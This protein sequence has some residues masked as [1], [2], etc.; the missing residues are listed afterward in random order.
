MSEAQGVKVVVQGES[1]PD[2][3]PEEVE[4]ESKGACFDRMSKQ[5]QEAL[6]KHFGS[7]EAIRRNPMLNDC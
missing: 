5:D 2:P 3:S 6:I 4:Y 1:T 7:I